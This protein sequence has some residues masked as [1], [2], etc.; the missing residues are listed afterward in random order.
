[1][2]EAGVIADK[3]LQS[4]EAEFMRARAENNRTAARTRAY[5]GGGGNVDQQFILRAP[6]AG[7]V[8]ERNANPGQEVR[9][10]GDSRA[11]FV[12]SDPSRLWVNLDL[13]E[14]A[15]GLIHSGMDVRLRLTTLG[16]QTRSA[17]I[18]HV[19]D[20]VDPDTRRTRARA[21]VANDDRL[22]KAEMFANADIILNRGEFIRVPS[23]AVILLGKTQYVFIEES[24]GRYRRQMVIAE[25]SGFDTMRVRQG[26]QAGQHVVSEGALL[27]QQIIALSVK[28]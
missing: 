5:G 3:E 2:H 10:D 9:P 27:L 21:T 15:L 28:K 19:A 11:L 18:E 24:P 13:P 6:I 4:S 22:L 25:E 20:F 23:T 7:M 16:E 8:V 26:M 1:L 12:I 17:R 14:T